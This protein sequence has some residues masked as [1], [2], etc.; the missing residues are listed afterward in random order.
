MGVD[1]SD[2]I[3]QKKRVV[4]RPTDSTD[5][6][7]VGQPVFY[8][9]NATT[10]YKERSTTPISG[11]TAYAEGSQNYN[12]R[13]FVVE[14][15]Y[16]DYAGD[17]NLE[18]FAG[19]VADLG[20]RAGADGDFINIFIPNGAIVP[21]YTDIACTLDRTILAIRTGADNVSYPGYDRCIGIA[22]ETKDRSGTAGLVWAKVDP[23]L[24]ESLGTYANH[25]QIPDES[26]ADVIVNR[27]YV[28]SAQTAGSFNLVSWEGWLDGAGGFDE[29]M[30]KMK[31]YLNAA[32]TD[33]CTTLSVGFTIE[34]AGEFTSSGASQYGN[35][36]LRLSIGTVGTPDLSGGPDTL[37]AVNIAYNVN[38]GGGAPNM[39]YAFHFN[40]G[41][42]KWD[43]LI[44]TMNAGDIGDATVSTADVTSQDSAS[45]KNIPVKLGGVVYYIRAFLAA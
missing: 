42:Y 39:A 10:D 21:V 36:P 33:G 32:A 34:A 45:D 17:V 43:G 8:N 2:P 25:L 35:G 11:G 26:G 37:C 19:I 6:L 3:A 13:L 30:F 38:E 23:N 44:H 9:S 7:I 14:R 22:K 16:T 41:T 15:P 4:W 5:V 31:A 1:G 40:S 27:M 29:G 28:D 20:S 12:A 24:F 18:A